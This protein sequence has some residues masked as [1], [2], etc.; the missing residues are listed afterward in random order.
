MVRT[1]TS[2]CRKIKIKSADC[3]HLHSVTL[4]G[5][6]NC[7]DNLCGEQPEQSFYDLL[8]EAFRVSMRHGT[9]PA[10]Q[11]SAQ[12]L[13]EGM[14]RIFPAARGAHWRIKVYGIS[15]SVSVRD[16]QSI[17]E[18]RYRKQLSMAV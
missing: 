18:V 9:T 7:I 5:R 8:L 6:V 15:H 14:A 12:T 2:V 1:K 11:A 17:I 3:E 10:A 4:F 13:C 16:C